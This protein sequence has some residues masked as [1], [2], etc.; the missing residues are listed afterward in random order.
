MQCFDILDNWFKI[1][2]NVKV[3]DDKEQQSTIEGLLI[4]ISKYQTMLDNAQNP[5]EKQALKNT[6]LSLYDKIE[7]LSKSRENKDSEKSPRSYNEV[8]EEKR[9]RALR[10]IF[11]F[12]C[13]K[14]LK[15]A[16]GFTFESIN[17][18]YSGMTLEKFSVM[19]K[20]FNIKLDQMVSIMIRMKNNW[21]Y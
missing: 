17:R 11:D 4:T 9:I 1:D 5:I 6:I 14:G 2:H 21:C 19:L 20:D 8:R 13:R 16:K 7:N 18:H 3:Y 12:F 10:D 15:I